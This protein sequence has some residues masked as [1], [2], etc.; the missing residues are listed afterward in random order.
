[1]AIAE[2]KKMTLIAMNSDRQKLIKKLQRL[3]C[4]QIIEGD[5]A[6]RAISSADSHS[7]ELQRRLQRIEW[8]IQKL[9]P[10][11]PVKQG[12]FPQ[13]PVA[14]EDAIMSAQAWRG[15]AMQLIERLEDMERS[16][17][18]LR[19]KEMRER[20]YIEQLTPWA[21][22]NEPLEKLTDTPSATIKTL[23]I[24]TRHL[25]AFER[26][27]SA[28]NVTP[29]INVINRAGG[30]NYV[31]VIAHKSVAREVD[32]IIREMSI[33][34]VKLDEERGTAA[35]QI[36]QAEGRIRRIDE[37][38]G[39]L[40]AETVELAKQIQPLRV[41][42]DVERMALDRTEAAGRMLGTKSAFIMSAWV[43]A[44][45]RETIEK[46]IER[47]ASTY[48]VAFDDPA[49]DE[50]PP[51]LLYNRNGLKPFEQVIN[52]YS[53]PDPR[54]F[55]PT[56]VMTPF[57]ICFFGMM[58]SDAGYGV[59]IMLLAALMV[60]KAKPRGQIGQIAKIMI[61]GGLGTVFWGIMY[62]GW[63]GISVTPVIFSPMDS[64]LECMILCIAIGYIHVLF[65][66]CVGFYISLKRKKYLDAVCDSLTWI[67]I[68]VGA[69]VAFINQLVVV[70]FN[71][72]PIGLG[73]VIAGFATIL[74]MGGRGKANIFKRLISGAGK[75]YDVTG[76]I[77]D[78]LSYVRLFG[79]GLATGVIGMVVNMLCMMMMGS[80]PGF[81]LACV[82][83]VFA[84]AFNLAINALG[85]YVNACRLQYIEFF[86]KFY[87]QGGD[88][89]KPLKYNTR[90]IDIDA[91]Y[92]LN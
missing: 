67:F 77:S 76:Y 49:D 81:I 80:V 17:S 42:R 44:D 63:F 10:H 22:L 26:A 20:A 1:M 12:M 65:G 56:A 40:A 82:I 53:L 83:L 8:A 85:A 19:T 28:L 79:M 66:V 62:G 89:F 2:M 34:R 78:I 70:S 30:D 11:D 33:E 72:T 5:E 50:K 39:Q 23:I 91:K 75:L 92:D 86:G 54:G 60:W 90:Y 4:V 6:G 9:N 38:R 73:M 48:E 52:L 21:Q 3:Q 71:F 57:F 84:H 36:D 15:E 69:P 14:G 24:S 32:S 55:D 29:S 37:V 59:A 13:R 25:E 45:M 58:V 41:L 43:P 87:E 16:L 31:L 74:L 18:D 47:N 27:M 51:T 88:P 68:L 35:F 61:W 7:G 46:V 64:A